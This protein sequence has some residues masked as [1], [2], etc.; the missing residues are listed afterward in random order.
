MPSFE[1]SNDMTS[2]FTAAAATA[3]MKSAANI[4]T[5]TMQERM[6]TV[7]HECQQQTASTCESVKCSD[8]SP[9][10][11]LCLCICALCGLLC[12]IVYSLH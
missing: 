4:W 11:A 10:L 8:A 1:V 9:D 7:Q 2:A 5:F 12:Y 6:I 3:R